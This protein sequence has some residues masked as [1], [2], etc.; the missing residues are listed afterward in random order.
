MQWHVGAFLCVWLCSV[1]SPLLA[2]SEPAD[3]YNA[4]VYPDSIGACVYVKQ[5]HLD[6]KF[7]GYGVY[8]PSDYPSLT[9][10]PLENGERINFTNIAQMTLRSKRIHWKK[11]IE[12]AQRH[13]FDDMRADGYRYWSEMEAEAVIKTWDGVEIKSRIQR[14]DH[15]DVFISGITD[16]GDFKLQIDQENNKTVRLEFLPGFIMQCTA[17]LQHLFP[18]VQWKFC[19]LC[20]AALKRINKPEPH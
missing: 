2:Q 9:C 16:R 6:F 5:V 7:S 18:N 10:I 17:D 8:V 4:K 11:Y 20:G 13:Q 14:P 1:Y 12:P 15:S 19:P 3:N